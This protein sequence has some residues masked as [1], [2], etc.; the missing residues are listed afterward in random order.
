MESYTEDKSLQPV[1]QNSYTNSLMKACNEAAEISKDALQKLVT[2]TVDTVSSVIEAVHKYHTG[3]QTHDEALSYNVT[4]TSVDVPHTLPDIYLF[5]PFSNEV[6]LPIP[7]V[8]PLYFPLG[9]DQHQPIYNFHSPHIY[10]PLPNGFIPEYSQLP[11]YSL[12][13]TFNDPQKVPEFYPMF[14]PFM[15]GAPYKQHTSPRISSKGKRKK[16]RTH[17]K[18]KKR[19][20][21]ETLHEIDEPYSWSHPAIRKAKWWSVWNESPQ[22]NDAN[23]FSHLRRNEICYDNADTCEIAGS[24]VPLT[25]KMTLAHM[26]PTKRRNSMIKPTYSII[27]EEKVLNL[28]NLLDKA[29]STVSVG[30]DVSSEVDGLYIRRSNVVY[31]DEKVGSEVDEPNMRRTSNVVHKDIEVGSELEVPFMRKISVATSVSD[32]TGNRRLKESKK[33]PSDNEVANIDA[34][35]TRSLSV[36]VK[37]TKNNSLK[38]RRYNIKLPTAELLGS[39]FSCKTHSEEIIQ[40]ESE[41]GPCFC[42]CLEAKWNPKQTL[43][44]HNLLNTYIST[45]RSDSRHGH[46]TQGRHLK[47]FMSH[48]YQDLLNL[49]EKKDSFCNPVVNGINSNKSNTLLSPCA[50]DSSDISQDTRSLDFDNTEEPTGA[51][52]YNMKSLSVNED[53]SEIQ[54]IPKRSDALRFPCPNTN[55]CKMGVLRLNRKTKPRQ[56]P[57]VF[58]SKDGHLIASSN[59]YSQSN[60]RKILKKKRPNQLNYLVH[61][62]SSSPPVSFAQSFVVSSVGSCNVKVSQ[63]ISTSPV[64]TSHHP[65]GIY[66]PVYDS[67]SL[68]SLCQPVNYKHVQR[69]CAN[70]NDDLIVRDIPFCKSLKLA[71]RHCSTRYPDTCCRYCLPAN[72]V[73]CTHYSVGNCNLMGCADLCQRENFLC[74][75]TSQSSNH[76]RC[77]CNT[78]KQEGFPCRQTKHCKE[79]GNSSNCFKQKMYRN[80]T[81]CGET[82]SVNGCTYITKP[83]KKD[84]YYHCEPKEIQSFNECCKPSTEISYLPRCSQHCRDYCKICRCS[85]Q[86]PNDCQVSKSSQQ[87]TNDCQV[88]NCSR[89]CPNDCHVSRCSRQFPY[90]CQV[91]K[92]SRQSTNDCQVSNCLR[93]CTNDCQVSKCSQ[94]YTNDCQVS[95]CTQHTKNS[96]F[97]VPDFSAQITDHCNLLECSSQI[98]DR[99]NVPKCSA[100]STDH[101]NVPKCSA[102]STDRCN[103]PKCYSHSTDRCNAP[104][105]YTQN[106]DRC[107]V[108][109]C[110]AQS[111]DHCNVPKCSAQSTDRCNV[112]K[113]SAQS[114]ARCNVP[115]CSA[116]ST[117][118]CNVLK[119]SAQ[120]TDRCNVHKYYAQSTNHCNVPKCYAQNTDHCNV[121]KCYAQTTNCCQEPECSTKFTGRCQEPECSTKFTGLCQE[122]ECSSKF[123]GRCQE[124]ECSTEFIGRCQEPECSSKFTGRCQEPECSTEFIG[125]CQE[126]ECSTTFTGRCQEA[127]CSAEIT[128]HCIVPESS[129]QSTDHCYLPKCSEETKD[130]YLQESQCKPRCKRPSMCYSHESDTNVIKGTNK[131]NGNKIL[132]ESR[133]QDEVL[134]MNNKVKKHLNSSIGAETDR[135]FEDYSVVSSNDEYSKTKFERKTCDVKNRHLSCEKNIQLCKINKKMTNNSTPLYKTELHKNCEGTDN[136]DFNVFSQSQKLDC[137]VILP[138]KDKNKYDQQMSK[139]TCCLKS[140]EKK[141]CLRVNSSV[142]KRTLNESTEMIYSKCKEIEIHPSKTCKEIEIHPSKTSKHKGKSQKIQCGINYSKQSCKLSSQQ[143]LEIDSDTNISNQE[144]DPKDNQELILST[145]VSQS[146]KSS[147][148]YS[149]A[150]LKSSSSSHSDICLKSSSSSHSDICLKSSSS[151]QIETCLKT[152]SIQCIES[153]NKTVE[154]YGVN[155]TPCLDPTLDFNIACETHNPREKISCETNNSSETTSRRHFLTVAPRVGFVCKRNHRENV[156]PRKQPFLSHRKSKTSN[157]TNKIDTSATQQFCYG[158]MHKWPHSSQV[159]VK[160]SDVFY[161]ISELNESPLTVCNELTQKSCFEPL[162]KMLHVIRESSCPRL[163]QGSQIIPLLPLEHRDVDSEVSTSQ[164]I[165]LESSKKQTNQQ[166]RNKNIL[167]CRHERK[168]NCDNA[169][170]SPKSHNAKDNPKFQNA[171]DSPRCHN[172]RDSTKYHKARDSPKCLNAKDTPKCRNARDSPKCLRNP[173]FSCLHNDVWPSGSCSSVE[174]P[175]NYQRLLQYWENM[176][177]KYEQ[178]ARKR[179]PGNDRNRQWNGSSG[180]DKK[181]ASFSHAIRPNRSHSCSI[182]E[183]SLPISNV[184]SH[185][186][187]QSITETLCPQTWTVHISQNCCQDEMKVLHSDNN[188]KQRNSSRKYPNCVGT[189]GMSLISLKGKTKHINSYDSCFTQKMITRNCDQ[190]A[191]L[192]EKKI[193]KHY[194]FETIKQ[195]M[196]SSPCHSCTNAKQEMYS[197]PCHSC[198]NAKQEMYSSPCHSCT[199]AKQDMYSSPCHSCTNVKQEMYSSPYHSCT[200]AKQEM[201]SSS[202]HSCTNAK[203][204]KY[205]SPCHSCTN[206]KQEKYSS[207][208]HSYTNAKQEKYSSPYSCTNAKQEMYSS[209]CHSCTNVKQ[210]KYSSPYHSC[211]NA[212]QEMYSSPCHNCTN[213]KQEKYSPP[214]HSCTNAKQEMY[215]SPCHSCTNAKQEKYSSPC[216]SCTNAKQEMY[217]SPCHSCTNVKQ[218]MYSSPYHSCT[219]AKQEKYSST[220]KHSSSTNNSV[221]IKISTIASQHN[222]C[223]TL[224]KRS[225]PKGGCCYVS[226]GIDLNETPFEPQSERC[227][228]GTDGHQQTDINRR[229]STDGQEQFSAERYCKENPKWRTS[230]DNSCV[231]LSIFNDSSLLK[232]T[233]VRPP[234]YYCRKIEQVSHTSNTGITHE[235]IQVTSNHNDLKMSA[236]HTCGNIKQDTL[237]SSHLNCTNTKQDTM[238]PSHHRCNNIKQDTM[239]SSHHSCTNIKQ[240][241]MSSSYHN[242]DENHS[243]LLDNSNIDKQVSLSSRQVTQTVSFISITSQNSK[244]DE[245]DKDDQSSTVL[246]QIWWNHCQP[247]MNYALSSD[248]HVTPTVSDVPLSQCRKTCQSICQWNSGWQGYKEDVSEMPCSAKNLSDEID[249]ISLDDEWNQNVYNTSKNSNECQ[250]Q[251]CSYPPASFLERNLIYSDYQTAICPKEEYMKYQTNQLNTAKF[252][253]GS[254]I[255]QCE[256]GDRVH[257]KKAGGHVHQ[258]KVGGHVPQSKAGGQIHQSE[259]VAHVPQSE[260][261][262]QVHQSEV[263]GHVPQSKAGG[264]IHPSEAAVELHQSVASGHVYQLR[265]HVHQRCELRQSE[266]IGQV[267]QSE[268]GAHVDLSQTFVQAH[269]SQA[270]GQVHQSQADG[271]VH[272]SQADGQVH[273]SQA[274]GQV[275]QSQADGK[276]HQSQSDGQVH[277][278]QA[279]G[280][281]HQSQADG[282]VH[283]SQSDG[284]VHQSQADGQVHQS[285]ADGQV[286]QSQAINHDSQQV[287]RHFEIK[288]TQR[289]VSNLSTERQKSATAFS[290]SLANTMCKHRTSY[291]SSNIDSMNRTL[292]EVS[293]RATFEKSNRAFNEQSHSLMA[294]KISAPPSLSK[295]QRE[296]IYSPIGD[297]FNTFKEHKSSLLESITILDNNFI[298]PLEACSNEEFWRYL[299]KIKN[300]LRISSI[301][302]S[303]DKTSH[304][305]LSPD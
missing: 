93:Q 288:P 94:E 227:F 101:C 30:D 135:H 279:D 65:S 22:S 3:T 173:F 160:N 85:R 73:T 283:Q 295:N 165:Q 133:H 86:Y 206:A 260:T 220:M 59:N 212:K 125:R 49:P 207:P 6:P 300:K 66:S 96:R 31:V 151:T 269:Q 166:R 261:C 200:N 266:A 171:R 138:C 134:C 180:I 230:L 77:L 145:S 56:E 98:T 190:G 161:C 148:S 177:Y 238:S 244:C 199:N 234:Y 15:Y 201:Y 63:T 229:T 292:A 296:F 95:K 169:K 219:N 129:A 299:Y 102:H 112:P 222:S 164:F 28:N 137:Q 91:L 185:Q 29:H 82:C 123:T 55:S 216:H 84:N 16:K 121:P 106:T 61:K 12:P 19:S 146:R 243:I 237:S 141:H 224:D 37:S 277:Q 142:K 109:K 205:S 297:K 132:K 41:T 298:G 285:Q 167:C 204:E 176:S 46:C 303:H 136:A 235:V 88:S 139:A 158:A 48:F 90:D 83:S 182:G 174:I 114:T 294:E 47:R 252:K 214:Y 4:S 42:E 89:Q 284:Q 2:S 81:H 140:E 264:Q 122:P 162:H 68:M 181:R 17:S 236:H 25:P 221:Q 245:T 203:Q 38:I 170:D 289:A 286:H 232:Q 71:R 183:Q 9:K 80:K 24:Y 293:H 107:N 246:S 60:T 153:T 149:D 36:K 247:D 249:V 290:S 20:K 104:K 76:D 241:T 14:N 187:N 53:L 282:K 301:S 188:K 159:H 208:Y 152:S 118:R 103:V 272:Q 196:Y 195:E 147:S 87:C 215:S 10:G 242:F 50:T 197:S 191:T 119:C 27:R 79:I 186:K 175:Y 192:N 278:S 74:S 163:F 39:I 304:I 58:L 267:H 194:S 240:D 64:S 52:C 43:P 13:Q 57:A 271:Q 253:A 120:S 155:E 254:Q 33:A 34:S 193:A 111:N 256:T 291:G 262:G 209:P 108:P 45:S 72:K 51:S 202:C 92:C 172:S 231:N 218:E 280:Q 225:F 23:H 276:V 70:I 126:P 305:T 213:V 110:S 179:T 217:S 62:K 275:H 263:R 40:P 5:H 124:P 131:E 211:T 100:Q 157:E 99:C 75:V 251:N 67:S 32:E 115:K 239:P 273:Q 228:I 143:L 127:E 210:E 69:T 11:I 248:S 302:Q 144:S 223:P 258:S 184:K 8:A 287:S 116:Q 265:F 226:P 259:I 97:F 233:N 268:A 281:V 7:H 257:K 274:D 105:C 270:D 168:Q 189:I 130:I 117:D 156:I 1:Q 154:A 128:D 78:K 150:N 178:D 54:K 18:T 255:S 113:C 21:K 44:R 26:H 198:T 250:S 35:L